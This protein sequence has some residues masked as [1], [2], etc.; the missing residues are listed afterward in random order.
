MG[1]GGGGRILIHAHTKV[2][3]LIGLQRDAMYLLRGQISASAELLAFLRPI[4]S[5]LFCVWTG[6]KSHPLAKILSLLIDQLSQK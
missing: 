1:R 2:H 6:P 3:R 4:L 5:E